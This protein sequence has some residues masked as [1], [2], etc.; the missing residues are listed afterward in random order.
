MALLRSDKCIDKLE[1]DGRR[2]A[3]REDR[4]ETFSPLRLRAI[5]ENAG[6]DGAVVVNKVRQ[7][8]GKADGYDADKDEYCDLIEAGI[9]DPAKVVRT[10]LQNAASVAALLLS[11]S[12]LITDIPKD[13][14]TGTALAVTGGMG[15]GMGGMGGMG[16]WAAWAAWAAWTWAAWVASSMSHTRSQAR[17]GACPGIRDKLSTMHFVRHTERLRT[18]RSQAELGTIISNPIHH[19]KER[20]HERYQSEAVG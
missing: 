5:A 6:Q 11:T 9:I 3:R 7:M 13:E 12:C 19:Q 18:V 1:L 15:G 14:E 8:K 10:A 4:A 2:S 17:L 20:T 16:A